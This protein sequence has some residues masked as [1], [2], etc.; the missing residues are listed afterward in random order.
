MGVFDDEIKAI[1]RLP[2]VI[3]E[4]IKD[5]VTK[6]GFVIKNYNTVK[7]LDEK[8]EDSE[9]NKLVNKKTKTPGYTNPYK[10]LR[11][12]RGLQVS[13]VDTHFS[14]E[15]HA[16]FQI[17]AEDGQFRIVSDIDYG[18]YVVKNYGE[19]ILG[20]QRQYLQDF[21]NTYLIDELKQAVNGYFAK[22]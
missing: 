3:D 14:G 17:I 2:E 15:F 19:K 10:R 12:K 18:E 6:Y 22:S 9:G 1:D 4:T 11:L 21:V 5:A 13:Y 7:Q 16:S 8:G 20:I